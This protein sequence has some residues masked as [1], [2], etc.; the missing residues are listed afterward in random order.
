[1][2]SLLSLAASH[3]ARTLAP[4]EV[5]IVEGE[6]GGSL[7][8]LER[9]RLRVERDGVAL[10]ILTQPGTLVGEMSVLL[11]TRHSATVRADGD[12]T[13]RIIGNAAEHLRQD[14]ELSFHVAGMLAGRLEATSSLLVE[15][16][17][18]HTGKTERGLLA[19]IFSA[20]ASPADG[21]SYVTRRDLF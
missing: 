16:T 10:V 12:S 7:Y 4:G 13:V 9:G 5:L 3:P 18:Q 14:P 2:S 6:T 19:S 20:L 8:L 11:G 21:E 17:K 1:M 15:L